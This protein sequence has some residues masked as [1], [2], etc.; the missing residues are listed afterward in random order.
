MAG[1]PA[2][3]PAA[4]RASAAPWLARP[5][6]GSRT[7]LAIMVFLSLRLGRPLARC[8]LYLIAGYFFAFGPTA[9]RSSRAY[10][11]R[12]LEREPTARDRF[13]H[14]FDFAATTLDRL[15]LLTDRSALFSITIEGEDIVRDLLARG[16]GAFL[17]GAHLGSFEMVSAVGRWQPGLRVAM[18]MLEPHANHLASLLPSV[19]SARAPEIIPLGH[20]TAML[21]IRDCLEEGKL[22]GMLADRTLGD[23]PAE[24]VSFLGVPALFP[25]GPMRA[26]AALRRPVIFMTGLYRGGNCY[27]I[28]FRQIADF[29]E[30]EPAG[31]EAAVRAAIGRYAGVLEELCRSDPYNW[32]NFYDFWHGARA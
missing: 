24:I 6:R 10:L 3:A 2:E 32:F 18:A 8:L 12:A 9:R 1:G 28:V 5:E 17:L 14:V 27:H 30:L 25:S 4:A 23:A 7:L 13:R 20:L 11:R 26:A 21:R 19:D 31:R 22:V 16:A 15:Y 29:S